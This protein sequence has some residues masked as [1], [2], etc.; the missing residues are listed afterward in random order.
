VIGAKCLRTDN[1]RTSSESKQTKST[2]PW[3]LM[4]RIQCKVLINNKSLSW[5]TQRIKYSTCRSST[6]TSALILLRLC[7]WQVAR[8]HM[9][10]CVQRKG[11]LEMKLKTKSQL[12]T[13]TNARTYGDA[14]CW[15][16]TE[17]AFVQ[18][19]FKRKEKLIL[20]VHLYLLI[21]RK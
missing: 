12:Q 17:F 7:A 2:N 16:I 8:L 5:V 11:F 1:S 3:K 18:L 13:T 21:L 15:I 19:S 20:L 10:Y 6:E 9:T 14:V 4:S